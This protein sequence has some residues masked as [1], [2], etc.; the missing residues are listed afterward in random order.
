M[1]YMLLLYGA[2][3]CGT[4]D[5]RRACMIASMGLCDELAAAGKYIASAPRGGVS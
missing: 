2:E 4:E 5:E 1:K 3:S